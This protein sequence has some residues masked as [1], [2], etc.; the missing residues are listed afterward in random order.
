MKKIRYFLEALLLRLLLV[1]FSLLP[2]DAASNAGGRIGRTLGPLLAAS[3]KAARNLE[4]ALPELNADER[5]KVIADM[6]E[7]LGRVM[8]EYPHLDKIARER[9]TLKN[10]WIFEEVI[11]ARG[12]AIFISAHLG[13]WEVLCPVSLLLYNQ[14]LHLTYRAPNNPYVDAMLMKARTLGG[15][16][17]AMAKSRSGGKEILRALQKGEYLGILIDQ[18]YNEG[19]AADFFGRQAMTNPVFAE[20]AAKYE[21]PLVPVQCKRLSG[22]RFELTIY[23]PLDIKAGT[24]DIIAQAHRLLES[25]IREAPGQWLWLHRRWDSERLKSN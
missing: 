3:R 25:W 16:I 14:P 11:K 8:A 23:E 21:C 18:K 17:K 6:W 10:A 2:V 20:L 5:K 24:E 19:I 9:V 7:N 4:N 13:N 12:G 1:I 15:Q 22:A